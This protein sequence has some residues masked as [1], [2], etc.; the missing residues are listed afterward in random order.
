MGFNC[1]SFGS[2]GC[3]NINLGSISTPFALT[4]INFSSSE[5]ILQDELSIA[6][7]QLGTS[8]HCEIGPLSCSTHSH[9]L[10]SLLE[11]FL[12]FP[13]CSVDECARH[14]NIGRTDTRHLLDELQQCRKCCCY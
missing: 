1:L 12:S 8:E 11:F 10:N 7:E 14:L 3:I 4:E 9:N 6:T 13:I 2:K 5:R